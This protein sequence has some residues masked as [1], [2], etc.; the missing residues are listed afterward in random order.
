MKKLI[1]ISLFVT[2][3]AVAMTPPGG[4][5]P[6]DDD[7]EEQ[8]QKKQKVVDKKDNKEKK[9]P[10]NLH[11][12][13]HQGN[14]QAL[15]KA[16]QEKLFDVNKVGFSDDRWICHWLFEGPMQE[17][18]LI[19][20]AEKGNVTA[21]KILLKYGAN[22]KTRSTQNKG[23]TALH[24]AVKSGSEGSIVELLVHGADINAQTRLVELFP[25]AIN[26]SDRDDRE[27]NYT[28]LHYAAFTASRAPLVRLLVLNGADTEL[29][30]KRMGEGNVKAADY[31]TKHKV[32]D[33][34]SVIKQAKEDRDVMLY[35]MSK[36]LRRMLRDD[37]RQYH[38]P[39]E[40]LDIIIA[41]YN[42]DTVFCLTTYE[43]FSSL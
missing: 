31:A 33:V 34:L 7:Q 24:Y 21:V 42:N 36:G 17:Y 9:A 19:V 29:E 16:I 35:W 23:E 2:A 41:Y 15:E 22:S 18:P 20:A 25:E 1:F 30:A 38:F 39:L 13:T 3:T 6:H 32:F 5:N 43:N 27:G 14:E 12:L 4:P 26:W 8:P 37:S 28:P 11:V 10:I 40:L